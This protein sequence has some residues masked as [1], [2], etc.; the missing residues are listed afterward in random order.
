[1]HNLQIIADVSVFHAQRRQPCRLQTTA[2]SGTL[3]PFS[4]P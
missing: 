2:N 4:G 1:M 3:A